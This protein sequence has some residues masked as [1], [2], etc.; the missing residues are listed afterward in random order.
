MNTTHIVLTSPDR[1]GLAV[2]IPNNWKATIAQIPGEDPADWTDWDAAYTFTDELGAI[3]FEWNEDETFETFAAAAE[4]AG[5][6][7]VNA[8]PDHSDEY[9]AVR[10]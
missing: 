9:L 10:K 8:H 7:I 4:A 3:D 2:V 6:H 5:F 1:P